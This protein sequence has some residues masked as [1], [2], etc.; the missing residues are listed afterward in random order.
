MAG[1]IYE[2]SEWPDSRWDCVTVCDGCH[3]VVWG[4]FWDDY[5]S[6]ARDAYFARNGWR[7][8][9][10]PGD[11]EILELCPACAVRALRRGETRGLADTWLRPTH[12]YTRAQVQVMEQLDLREMRIPS[13]LLT[14]GGGGMKLFNG[15][16]LGTSGGG[17]SFDVKVRKA[18]AFAF[19]EPIVIDPEKLGVDVTAKCING[20]DPLHSVVLGGVFTPYGPL[21]TDDY[22]RSI[23]F[24]EYGDGPCRFGD[25]PIQ[26]MKPYEWLADRVYVFDDEAVA[27]FKDDVARFVVE[28]CRCFVGGDG[29]HD[30]S[31]VLCREG[32]AEQLDLSSDAFAPM[33]GSDGNA[34]SFSY[35]PCDRLRCVCS[36]NPQKGLG[37]FH[38]W[39]ERG[40]TY[41]AVLGPCAYERRPEK[42]L[43]LPDELWS[44]NESWMRD[45][46]EQETS[47][48]LCLGVVSRRTNIRFVEGGGARG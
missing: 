45:F 5:D 1:G 32:V 20:K 24:A 12:A 23:R 34:V 26:V 2:Q 7:N 37:V 30:R 19:D 41:Q 43:T 17:K 48:F 39:T 38:V 42:A 16:V 21:L 29:D 36:T 11:T 33:V 9:C 22:G 40:T 31:V 25:R 28:A 14:E 4:T 6:A 44:R 27:P 8:Y 18:D 47:D 13:L 15:Y 10:V 46:F 35:Q 3:T